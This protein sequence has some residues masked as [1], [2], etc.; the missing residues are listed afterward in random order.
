MVEQAGY[1]D[2]IAGGGDD[3][4]NDM[5]LFN[6]L[7]FPPECLE[8]DGFIDEFDASKLGPIPSDALTGLFPVQNDSFNAPF[9]PKP[10][11]SSLM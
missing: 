3:Y 4:D 7:E 8:E 10:S 11:V 1:W 6:V 9:K 5:D 2:G